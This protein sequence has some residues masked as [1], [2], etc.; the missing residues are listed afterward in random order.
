MIT[1]L[2]VRN[3]KSIGKRGID[4]ELKPLVIFVGPNGSGKSSILHAIDWLTTKAEMPSIADLSDYD[5]RIYGV[6]SFEDLIHRRRLG[7]QLEI[8]VSI[9]LRKKH[10]RRLSPLLDTVEWDDR[11]LE[12]PK[13]NV[14]SYNITFKPETKEIRQELSLND[15]TIAGFTKEYDITKERHI[16]V[17]TAPPTLSRERASSLTGFEDHI[18]AKRSFH[19]LEHKDPA[20]RRFCE[21]V[22]STLSD[23]FCAYLISAARGGI[24]YRGSVDKLRGDI[25]VGKLGE[26]VVEILGLT[27]GASDERGR[28]I[29]DKITFWGSNFGLDRLFGGIERGPTL[30][31]TYVDPQ[32]KTGL[33]SSLASHGSRQM[34]AFITQLFYEPPDS[35]LMVEEPEISLHPGY[36]AK[37]PLLLAEGVNEGK[38][39][40]VTTHSTLL[41]LALSRAIHG[42]VVDG[43]TSKGKIKRKINLNKEDVAVYHVT[44]GRDGCTEVGRL[45]LTDEGLIDGGV[46]SFIDVER[47]L[48]SRLFKRTEVE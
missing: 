10:I 11:G 12:R 19:I 9:D 46:P 22:M 18:L 8:G 36:Q 44:R 31:S 20:L 45:K 23:C 40:L 34:L 17:Y 37:L 7:E 6:G 1:R 30:R 47:E 16:V 38:Q 32:L 33:E 26:D 28:E 42:E 41:L 25:R 2:R 35:T 48:Y 39:V 15:E 24:D 21:A 13:L 43:W 14:A 29:G 5:K 3:F 27:I 4:I